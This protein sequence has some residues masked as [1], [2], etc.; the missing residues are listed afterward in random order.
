VIKRRK[1]I[2]IEDVAQ[3]ANVSITTVSR[4]LNKVPTVSK[5]NQ[6]KV[7][8][9]IAH[10][11]FKPDV[12]AQR[13][14]R[15]V[16]TAIGF[17]IPGYPGIFHSFYAME[18]IRGVGHACEMLKLDLV[19][20]ITSGYNPI[21]IHS[22]GGIVFADIIENRKQVEDALAAEIPSIVINHI[23]PD[24]P[25]NYLGVDNVSGAQSAV[26]YLAGLGHKH[27]ATITGNP[28][29][30]SAAHRLEGYKQALK[31]AK[32]EFKDEFVFEGDFS[33]RSG[34]IGMEKLLSLNPRPTAVFVASDEMALECISVIMEKG[35]K[36]PKDISV[37]GFDDN[38]ACLYGP[39]AL[40]TVRQPLF[41]MAMDAVKY[42]FNIM[43][44][45]KKSLVEVVLPP[46][47]I[48]RDSCS[49]PSA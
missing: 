9:A 36:V 12:S 42:V 34:R 23:V 14:A 1:K 13:L 41:Q 7:E 15:G 17:V 10:L 37:I 22:V 39:V 28:Q 3:R 38:P 30:Q 31:K 46:Q 40:T 20:H 29:T 11:K 21:D 24:L 8:E 4:V 18:L 19:F 45:K 49:S 44:G 25:V 47:L 2:S 5:K 35:L 32:I 43:Q 6:T 27:I 26:E 16:N 33:R 48:I